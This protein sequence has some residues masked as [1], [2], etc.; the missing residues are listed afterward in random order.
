MIEIGLIDCSVRSVARSSISEG[1]GLLPTDWPTPPDSG[2]E[3]MVGASASGGLD[4]LLAP[5]TVRGLEAAGGGGDGRRRLEARLRYGWA[6]FGGRYTTR[7][8]LGIAFSD[9]ARKYIHAWPLAEARAAGLVFGIDVEG[10]RRE[11]V[12][13]DSEPEHRLGLGLGWR[14]EG[15]RTA[16][17]EV[18][19]KGA[20]LDATNDDAPEHR[21]GVRISAR[22]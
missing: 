11:R 21:L 20:R 1:A 18:R 4:A 22:R 8:E 2:E 7:S 12:A 5:D 17:F 19:F 15:A 14:L 9:T 3:T 6:S 10:A 13:G 16:A